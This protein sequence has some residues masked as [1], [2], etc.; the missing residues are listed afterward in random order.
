LS[1]VI[2]VAAPDLG[3]EAESVGYFVA[4]LYVIAMIT[5]LAS[6]PLLARFGAVRVFQLLLLATMIAAGAFCLPFAAAAAV[7]AIFLGL[8]SGPMNPTGSEVLASVTQPDNRALVFSIKQ[9]AT[10]GGGM[11]AGS[12]LPPLMLAYGWQSA[13][14]FLAAASAAVMLLAPL[15]RLDARLQPA[16]RG[17]ASA[18]DATGLQRA[19]GS[20]KIVMASA[21][22]R[23]VT[24]LGLGLGFIQLGLA[25]YLVVFLW[26]EV[27]YSLAQAGLVFSTLHISGIVA[28]LVLGAITDTLI[29]AKW[30][31][32]GLAVVLSGALLLMMKLD[33]SWPLGL[34]YA[35]VALVGATANAWVGLYFAELARLAPAGQLAAI[36]GGSQFF[37]FG[38]L[39]IGPVVFGLVL[40][41]TDSYQACFAVLAVVAL[42][43]AGFLALT[44]Q[45]AQA[46]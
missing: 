23:A 31:L 46:A 26:K 27:G 39:V 30:V 15:G 3:L 14:V 16:K 35:L 33:A 7:G 45:P 10:P 12:V 4:I 40:Q 11:I 43:A 41:L 13:L 29:P 1:V 9:C 17:G 37:T 34:V 25:T 2:P 28:R 36:T 22:I 8:S 6:G 32:V 20:V 42:V 21:P 18:S 44:R 5:G 38:G 24:V 19:F